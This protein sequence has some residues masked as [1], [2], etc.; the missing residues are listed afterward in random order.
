MKRGILMVFIFILLGGIIGGLVFVANQGE[1]DS[2]ITLSS[3][4]DT[5]K[6]GE[7]FNITLETNYSGKPFKAA[8]IYDFH[9]KGFSKHLYRGYIE[10]IDSGRL[11]KTKAHA[12]YPSNKAFEINE[13]GHG[14]PRNFFVDEG[15]YYISVLVYKCENISKKGFNCTRSSVFNSQFSVLDETPRKLIESDIEPLSTPHIEIKV[16]GGKKECEEDSDCKEKMCESCKLGHYKCSHIFPLPR[17]IEC[18]GDSDCKEGYHCSLEKYKCV[19]DECQTDSDCT[20]SCEGCINNTMFCDRG[21]CKECSDF[22][23]PCKEGYICEDWGCTDIDV[24]DDIKN[25]TIGEKCATSNKTEDPEI[26][27]TFS[28][29]SHKNG[30]CLECWDSGDC[31]EEYICKNYECIKK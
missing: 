28:T 30:K 8:I 17:C 21:I 22:E 12:A 4:K 14:L 16:K 11:N 26:K 19:E 20:Q 6:I 15:K 9:R 29:N 3:E 5:Y 13:R 23:R 2:I 18:N 10:K 27:C 7:P 31:K 25:C 1:E 24:L